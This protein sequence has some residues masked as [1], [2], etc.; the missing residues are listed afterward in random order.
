MGTARSCFELDPDWP[1]NV[2]TK[3]PL[4]RVW[5]KK[6]YKVEAEELSKGKSLK[7]HDFQKQFTIV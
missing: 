3:L 2:W 6:K 5:R 7:F 1:M 4:S